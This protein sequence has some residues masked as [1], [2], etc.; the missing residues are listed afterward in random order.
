LNAAKEKAMGLGLI[1]T[2]IEGASLLDRNLLFPDACEAGT[3]QSVWVERPSWPFPTA[4]CRRGWARD[5][6]TNL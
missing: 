4:T 2:M 6:P 1:R 5:C 3:M